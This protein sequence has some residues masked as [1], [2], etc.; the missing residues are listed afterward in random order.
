MFDPNPTV[1]DADFLVV[2][3]GIGGLRAA[4]RAKELGL[5]VAVAEK[6]MVARGGPCI[7]V[8]SQFAPWHLSEQELEEWMREHVEMS[9]YLPD[10]KWLEIYLREAP[11][12]IDDFAK[13]GVGYEREPDGKIKYSIVRGHRVGMSVNVDG[14]AMMEVVG[15]EVRRRR[16]PV[17]EKVMVTDL[18]TSDGKSPTQGRVTGAVG[19]HVRT[20][21][22]FVF[23]AKAVQVGTGIFKAKMHFGYVDHCTGDGHAMCYRAGAEMSGLEFGQDASF[24]YWENKFYTPGQAKIQ[25]LGVRLI[26]SRGERFMDQY[27]P[28]WKELS[29]L[30]KIARG[31][32]TE[33]FE[34]RG[35]CYMDMR[36]YTEEEYQLLRRVVPTLA[37]SF[38]EFGI[39]PLKKPLESCPYMVIGSATGGGLRP[40]YDSQTN[41]PGLYGVGVATCMP[42]SMS[43]HSGS[44]PSTFSNVGG[45][46]AANHVAS[47]AKN[48]TKP[49]V[50]DSQ[51][52]EFKKRFLE[53]LRRLKQVRPSD[54]HNA[55][56]EVTADTVFALFKNAERITKVQRDLKE[57]EK[58]LAP[59][60]FA[61]DMHEC[62]KANEVKNYLQMSQLVC[63]ASR[64]REESRA[65]HVRVDFPFRDDANW[66]KWVILKRNESGEGT[67]STWDLPISTYPIQP[68]KREKIP[69][70]FPI[71]KE[72]Q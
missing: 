46:R 24:S 29:S 32:I 28:E 60:I 56:G 7:Y 39:D 69:Y 68:K 43:G 30:Y 65:E 38:D 14:R 57:I 35:P 45:Y 59:K 37:R 41:V 33:N 20:G 71:P 54:V 25:G 67:V 18:L 70:S 16:I 10:Q 4:L 50:H 2:G 23:R 53:P 52:K 19:F 48:A 64:A 6:T 47:W 5:T 66:L 11:D 61:P 1:V 26:N 63:L 58:N 17:F 34:G 31:I 27:D 55:I 51:I 36:H 22:F 72:L 21:E 9:N 62:V 12:R 8:H 13:M 44:G 42:V 40:D 49:E 15:K 3:G